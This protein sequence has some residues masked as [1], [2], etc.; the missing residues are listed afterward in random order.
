M[1]S[2][3]AGA[4][5]FKPEVEDL[6]VETH[7]DETAQFDVHLSVDLVDNMISIRLIS[8]ARISSVLIILDGASSR[9]NFTQLT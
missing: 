1:Y 3:G 8:F 2:P 7:T 9:S 4:E 5:D 6:F